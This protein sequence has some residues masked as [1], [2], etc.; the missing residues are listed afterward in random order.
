LKVVGTKEQRPEFDVVLSLL[1]E[2][3]EKQEA[4]ERT[5]SQKEKEAI[6]S[7][8]ESEELRKKQEEEMR[9]AKQEQLRRQRILQEA[10][11]A[12]AE[13]VTHQISTKAKLQKN[14]L[15]R[16]KM[17]YEKLEDIF[18]DENMYQTFA[19]WLKEEANDLHFYKHVWEFKRTPLTERRKAILAIASGFLGLSKVENQ[20]SLSFVKN[21]EDISKII[22]T[23]LNHDILS[24][25]YDEIAE[26]VAIEL[27]KRFAEFYKFKEQKKNQGVKSIG[28]KREL[29]SDI[30]GRQSIKQ[31]DV[32]QKTFQQMIEDASLTW[33]FEGMLK[34]DEES[35]M[36]LDL[37]HCYKALEQF[38]S[39][40]FISNEAL[41]DSAKNLY[42]HFLTGVTEEDTPRYI[43]LIDPEKLELVGRAISQDKAAQYIFDDLLE[44]M[45]DRLEE[46][47]IQGGGKRS[48]RKQRVVM[49]QVRASTKRMKSKIR[50]GIP[51]NPA[52]IF[53]KKYS[54]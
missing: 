41:L 47:W 15:N 34:E 43:G 4:L 27:R 18:E 12:R 28:S 38:S 46:K 50:L 40:P 53:R 14:L 29:V 2:L 30:S 10:D 35:Q 16:S 26:E 25:I 3:E 51:S 54:W 23:I 9:I 8:I 13:Q 48:I 36:Y 6:K 49:K 39:A 21:I 44:D 17:D 33:I 31:I 45:L 22:E 37:F 7:K 52:S 11:R 5:C 20:I 24:T 42:N 1:K 32:G 19:K